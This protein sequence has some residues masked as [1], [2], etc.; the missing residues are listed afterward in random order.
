MVG[1]V[2]QEAGITK[3]AAERLIEYIS[4][5]II[6]DLLLDG[7]SELRGLGIFHLVDRAAREFRN[8]QTGGKVAKGPR[9]QIK[10]KPFLAVKEQVGG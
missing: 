7:R 5:S 9:K 3:A 4:R 1:K 2:A 8:P 10:F 6:A